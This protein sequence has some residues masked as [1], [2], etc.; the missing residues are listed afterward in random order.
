M[1]GSVRLESKAGVGSVFHFEVSLDSPKS[2]SDA[3]LPNTDEM[4]INPVWAAQFEL[5]VVE[6][7][8]V[9]MDTISRILRRLGF[10]LSSARNGAEAVQIASNRKFDLILTDLQMPLMG[11][12]DAAKIIRA[13][14]GPCAHVPILALTAFAVTDHRD[15]CA[16][17]GMNGFLTKPI[18][19]VDLKRALIQ[20][21]SLGEDCGS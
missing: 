17:V 4:I 7:D 2:K 15:Q 13:S 14:G 21:L 8:P 20:N 9:N 19:F 5:L 3:K 18:S 6:D 12:V 16:Q 10:K 1:G 11:G